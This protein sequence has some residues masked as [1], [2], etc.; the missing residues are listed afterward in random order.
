MV[1]PGTPPIPHVGGPITTGCPTVLI[2][3]MPAARVTDM[4]ICVGPPDAIALGSMTVMIGGMQA[5]RIGDLSAHGGIVVMGCPTVIIGDVGMGAAGIWQRH[6]QLHEPDDDTLLEGSATS[7][8]RMKGKSYSST[9]SKRKSR[10]FTE[11]RAMTIAASHDWV[12]KEGSLGKWG[13]DNNNFKAG[14]YGY[15]ASSGIEYSDGTLAANVIDASVHAEAISGKFD[16]DGKNLGIEGSG[17]VLSAE[18]EASLGAEW[19]KKAKE[20]HAK[21]GGSADLVKGEIAGKVHIPLFG[22]VLTL[23]G[24][25]EGQIGASAEAKAGGGWSKEDGAFFGAQAKA[26]AGIGGGLKFAIGF[27]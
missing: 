26:G 27:K 16:K 12:S 3:G 5:A 22:H 10:K 25:L 23:G 18:A 4:A 13:D 11:P 1:T 19:S 17:K 24:G 8:P 15:S 9:R 20:I 14:S 6:E 21:I 7:S 2:G